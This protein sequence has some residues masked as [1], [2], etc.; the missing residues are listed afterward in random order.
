MEAI[1]DEEQALRR[2]AKKRVEM[3]MGFL[4]HLLVYVLVNGGLMLLQGMR[5]GNW[6]HWPMFGWGIGLAIHGIVTLVAL[7]GADMRE[8]MM[9][10]EIEALRRRR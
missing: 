1:S 4:T 6:V 3:K 8:R 7:Q 2:R 5:G 10:R 9:E